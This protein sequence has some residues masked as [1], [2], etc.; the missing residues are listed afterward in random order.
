MPRNRSGVLFLFLILAP[1]A[2]AGDAAPPPALRPPAIAGLAVERSDGQYVAS[3]RLE[4]AFDA[5]TLGKIDSGLEVLFDYRLEVV[6]RRRFWMDDRTVQRRIL[7]STRYDSLSRQYNL[8]LSV[9]G[10]VERSSTTDKPA[11]MRRWMTEIR[12]IVLGPVSGFTPPGEFAVRVKS[13]FPP[14]FVL[15]FIP[16]DR[17]TPWARIPLAPAAPDVHDAGR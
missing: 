14:R 9:D 5:E 4:S 2:P 8:L 15:F 13:D 7:A 17:D 10:Q 6:R 12:G 11:E 1:P 3:F 16:W